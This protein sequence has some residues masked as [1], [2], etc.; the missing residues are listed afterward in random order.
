MTVAEPPAGV[1]TDESHSSPA[2]QRAVSFLTRS[3]G[4]VVLGLLIVAF[5]I[6]LPG[7]FL[8]A[9]N[10]SSMIANQAAPGIMALGLLFPLIANEF[11]FSA[12]AVAS[13][14]AVAIAVLAGEDQIAWP[15]AALIVLAGAGVF[16]LLNG[17]LI[18]YL[19]Y[20]SFVATLATGGIITG[21]TL[22]KTQGA[23]VYQRIPSSFI[24]IGND[25]VLHIPYTAFYLMGAYLIAALLLR[26]TV[27]GRHHE[28]IGK[29]PLA[30]QLAGVPVRRHILVSFVCSGVAAGVAGIV[31]VA[32]LGSA[33]PDIGTSY[34]LNAFAAVFLGATMFR[35]GFFN[36]TGTVVA[37][38]LVAV[39]VNGLSLAGV[40]TFVSEIV[41]GGLLL[42]AVGLSKF[43]HLKLRLRAARYEPTSNA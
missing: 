5:S 3:G 9:D 1:K 23:T 11:D 32:L 12:G 2:P 14:A 35:P 25:K 4:L 17:A 13:S 34:L 38:L 8:T 33:P 39:G 10:F 15:I 27:W 43:E 28:A 20:N 16:G 18:A 31:V 36:A 41:T 29:A 40:S 21:V 37:I 7:T 26:Q 42:A 19:K 22:M 6:S 30:V 24:A